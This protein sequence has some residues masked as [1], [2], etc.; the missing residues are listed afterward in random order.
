MGFHVD[1]ASLKSDAD[2]YFK[3]AEKTIGEM[4]ST[5]AALN[6]IV[7]SNALYGSAGEA[8]SNDVN[9]NLN[10]ML[11]ALKDEYREVSIGFKQDIQG[12]KNAVG[13]G[14]D[15]A[16]LDEDTLNKLV[17]KLDQMAKDQD[18]LAK[19]GKKIFASIDDIISLSAPHSSFP[20]G[21]RETKKQIKKI[22]T[23]VTEFDHAKGLESNFAAQLQ[24]LNSKLNQADQYGD[25]G[26]NDS[27]FLSYLS[28]ASFAAEVAERDA[29]IEAGIKA[30]R[31]AK[32]DAKKAQAEW[33]ARHPAEALWQKVEKAVGTYWQSVMKV[34][35]KEPNIVTRNL[36]LFAE[37]AI[38][39]VV[40]TLVG[41]TISLVAWGADL[42][43]EA[44]V[45]IVSTIAGHPN[46]SVLKDFMQLANTAQNMYV[47]R[48][49]V[50]K[51]MAGM[52][53]STIGGTWQDIVTGNSYE[54][55]NDFGNVAAL[56]VPVGGEVK[57]G[58][59]A[60]EDT[61]K[62]AE[63]TGKAV[64]A[65]KLA[66]KATDV[67]ESAAK[68][69]VEA[70]VKSSK[71][72]RLADKAVGSHAEDVVEINKRTLSKA[73]KVR[74]SRP[75]HF[76]KSIRQQVWDKAKDADGIVR[77]PLTKQPMKADEPWDMGHKP[78]REFW[79]YQQDAANRK[80]SRKEFLDGYND[81]NNYR[82]ELPSSNRGHY[83]ENSTNIFYR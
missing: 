36:T 74:Y 3:G 70:A 27:N 8:V 47:H 7:T 66:G 2:A 41:D 30:E 20:T 48:G 45:L 28:D 6:K 4:E 63:L 31:Q 13:E 42:K 5:K 10:A 78:G 17:T 77:D 34:T 57:A 37:G 33:A 72:A 23:K 67:G 16:V 65:G 21:T 39:G 69:G 11:T 68:E 59:T 52:I 22:I 25:S 19:N 80:L 38:K 71:S 55:G 9:N 54:M 79:K 75:S 62:A 1:L 32:L 26:Y 43:D 76:R 58:V 82:P 24:Q 12:F 56:F 50:A 53:G 73:E 60:A 46:K 83:G 15:S 14:S 64:E 81:V 61:A 44:K 40:G 18:D 49:Q 51:N 35:E 29:P